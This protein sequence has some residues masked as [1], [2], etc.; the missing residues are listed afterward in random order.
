MQLLEHPRLRI[1]RDYLIPLPS[2]GL[3]GAMAGNALF[4]GG[5]RSIAQVQVTL[6]G[7]EFAKGPHG[8]PWRTHPALPVQRT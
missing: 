5:C 2:P 3:E 8:Y 1:A 7:G 6:T 4:R